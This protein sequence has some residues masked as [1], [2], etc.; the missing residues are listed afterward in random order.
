MSSNEFFKPDPELRALLRSHDARPSLPQRFEENVWRRI[1]I[2]EA[3]H[4]S[5]SHW[6]SDW[7]SNAIRQPAFAGALSVLLVLGGLA[8]GLLHGERES[9]RTHVALGARYLQAVDPYLATDR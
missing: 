8:V 2:G 9:K 5:L 7:I 6:V 3:T 4:P 1:G